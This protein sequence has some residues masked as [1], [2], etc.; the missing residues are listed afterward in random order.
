MDVNAQHGGDLV[1]GIAPGGVMLIAHQQHA[2]VQDLL[3][4]CGAI[5]RDGLQTRAGFFGQFHST[6]AI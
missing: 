5:A 4:G 2:G 6:L 3:G 1:I